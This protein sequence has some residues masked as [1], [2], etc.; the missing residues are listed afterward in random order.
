MIVPTLFFILLLL[1]ILTFAVV[2]RG[3]VSGSLSDWMQ[4][5]EKCD[6]RCRL[7][8]TQILPTCR[9]VSAALDHLADKLVLRKTPCDTVQSWTSL[10]PTLTK[11]M[12]VAALPHLKAA[13]PTLF[14]FTGQKWKKKQTDTG[15]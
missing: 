2:K 7:R 14:S 6:K 11:R 3:V 8:R 15:C 12:T 9:H 1:S 4:R 10:F 13:A 5:F